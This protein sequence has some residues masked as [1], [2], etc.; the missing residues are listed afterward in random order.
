MYLFF[1][2]D[3]V[4]IQ[5]WKLLTFLFYLYTHL[6]LSDHGRIR[7]IAVFKNPGGGYGVAP[8]YEYDSVKALVLYYS[9]NTMEKHNQESKYKLLYPAFFK[10]S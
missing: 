9:L 2:H 7:H 3:I 5:L 10:S 6:P 1:C 4:I 8:P